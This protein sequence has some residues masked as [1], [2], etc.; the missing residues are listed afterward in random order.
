MALRK[1]ILFFIVVFS[2]VILFGCGTAR[3][4]PGK[5]VYDPDLP[6]EKTTMVVFVGSIQ[7]QQ[8][9]GIDVKEAWY[10]NGKWRKNTV[11]LP[12][13]PAAI[14]FNCSFSVS[15]GNTIWSFKQEELELR[16]D[17]E[18]GKEY[19]FSPYSEKTGFLGLGKI[20]VGVA[21]W[22]SAASNA[23]SGGKDKAIKYWEL[24]ETAY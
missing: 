20:K 15:Q 5:I 12:G 10:P 23:T 24:G 1:N 11:T 9:N 14:V 22:D 18:A 3:T 13:G 8:Y 19:T 4:P 6:G 16:F 7:V 17:F 21:I 2:V